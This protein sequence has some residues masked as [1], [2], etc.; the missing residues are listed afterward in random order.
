M[1]G[2]RLQVDIGYHTKNRGSV[3]FLYFWQPRKQCRVDN[4]EDGKSE[5]PCA[6]NN[7]RL[8]RD[9]STHRAVL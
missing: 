8:G 9:M 4:R 7:I 1:S 5:F 6:Y 3:F 2:F